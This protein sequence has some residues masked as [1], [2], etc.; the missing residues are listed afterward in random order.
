MLKRSG[1][2][3]TKVPKSQVLRIDREIAKVFLFTGLDERQLAQVK[4]NMGFIELDEGEYLFDHGQKAERF[5]LL[6]SGHIKLLRLSLDGMEKVIEIIEPGQTFAAPLMFLPKPAYP[7][8]AEAISKSEVLSFDNRVFLNILENSFETCRRIMALM[9]KR[10]HSWLDEIDN[11]TLQNATYRLI[12]YL[13]CQVPEGC[14]NSCDIRFSVPK[15][16]IASRLSIKPETL[17]RIL[18]QLNA[19]ELITVAGR[20]VHIRNIDDLCLYCRQVEENDPDWGKKKKKK[21]ERIRN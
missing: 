21:K 1:S 18:H 3:N 14:G 11:L 6:L 13:M 16:V 10:L 15:H 19:Q 4:Q 12:N 8:T 20:T 9:S 17:S 2:K 7:V 5:F